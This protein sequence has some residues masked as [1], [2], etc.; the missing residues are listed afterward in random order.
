MQFCFI[1]YSLYISMLTNLFWLNVCVYTQCKNENDGL[2]WKKI[3]M[4]LWLRLSALILSVCVSLWALSFITQSQRY[5]G[6]VKLNIRYT[7]FPLAVLKVLTSLQ[8]LDTVMVTYLGWDLHL[9]DV[10]GE[11]SWPGLQ[12]EE[13]LE[14]ESSSGHQQVRT[15]HWI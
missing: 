6:Q 11:G 15:P 4:R 8:W 14:S 3:L 13:S 12:Q 5:A 10:H 2:T 7:V 9:S 1:L